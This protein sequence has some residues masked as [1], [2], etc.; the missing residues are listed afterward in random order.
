MFI[1]QS[2]A[3]PCHTACE[4]WQFLFFYYFLLLFLPQYA[5]YARTWQMLIWIGLN[6]PT[7]CMK[8]TQTQIELNNLRV[9]RHPQKPQNYISA[10]SPT[11]LQRWNYD[12]YGFFNRC[13]RNHA[14]YKE[15]VKLS[16][17]VLQYFNEEVSWTRNY[18]Y[19]GVTEERNHDAKWHKANEPE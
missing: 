4:C 9:K 15:N 19:R 13:G 17:L 14:G 3:I 1:S 2:T 12:S 7:R 11:F 6:S 10:H 16:L 18:A 8:I 5:D